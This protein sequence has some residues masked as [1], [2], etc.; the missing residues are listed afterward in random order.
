MTARESLVSFPA[1]R[2]KMR[3]S[4]SPAVV[5]PTTTQHYPS[6]CVCVGSPYTPYLVINTRVT[7]SLVSM[8]RA[9]E[10]V[11]TENDMHAGCRLPVFCG[12]LQSYCL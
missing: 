3:E 12:G 7:L 1:L 8:E 2:I 9:C 4:V 6:R 11:F 10:S 5:V